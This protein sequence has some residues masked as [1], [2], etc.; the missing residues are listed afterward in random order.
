MSGRFASL[1]A[2]SPARPTSRRPR[3]RDSQQLVRQWSLVLL[4]ARSPRWFTVKQLADQFG[5]SKSTIERDLATIEQVFPVDEQRDGAQRR[6]YRIA[7]APPAV[8]A[9]RPLGPMQLVALWFALAALRP[10]RDTP[11]YRDLEQVAQVVRALLAAR[12]HEWLDRI[13]S[14]FDSDGTLPAE[15]GA[16]A[17]VVDGLVDA[18]IRGRL[19][20][21][22][23]STRSRSRPAEL[24]LVPR[25][26]ELRRG[27]LAL[28][29]K[30]RRGAEVAIDVADIAGVV[31]GG[32]AVR[33]R[34]RR[35]ARDPDTGGAS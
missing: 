1:D 22:R 29:G 15:L 16:A 34:R 13:A 25:R 32:A 14:V 33:A 20:A 12:D 35:G 17:D 24:Q 23:F 27:R 21:V 10:L 6:R 18:A 7:H 19:C 2:M 11:L 3:C 31:V 8:D 26:L 4:L 28:R 9:A 30:P 5:V